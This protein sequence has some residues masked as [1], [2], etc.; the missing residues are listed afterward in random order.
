MNEFKVIRNA[1]VYA[2]ED[3]G[4]Q[5]VLICNDKMIDIQPNLVFSYDHEEIDASEKYLIP[6]FIDQHVHIIGGGGE[7]G[8]SSLI[9]EI[10]MT[11][12]IQY[13]VTTVVG[14]LGTDAH[15][16]S[17]E[18]LVA[19]T[20]ALREQGMSAYCLTGSYAIPTTTLTGSIGKDIAFIDERM[21]SGMSEKMLIRDFDLSRK[22]RKAILDKVSA[23][24]ILQ[25]ALDTF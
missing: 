14:L 15:V 18:Q 22:K 12:C 21:T 23:A 7:N 10:Q 3:A 1:H 25:R 17:I 9:R 24:E 2:P 5:D 11:D 19:K 13:G 4:I 20:K 8:F 6:G 16:K